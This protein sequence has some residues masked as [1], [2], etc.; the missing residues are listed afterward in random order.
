MLYQLGIEK[1]KILTLGSKRKVPTDTKLLVL[2]KDKM[3]WKTTS[4]Q[5]G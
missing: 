1:S 3:N 4:K 2:K 5:M